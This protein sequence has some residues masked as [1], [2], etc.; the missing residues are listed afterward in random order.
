VGC[1]VADQARLE[2]AN[3]VH[4][5]AG[6]DGRDGFPQEVE[7]DDGKYNQEGKSAF[8][9]ERLFDRFNDI[10]KQVGLYH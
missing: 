1:K 5:T 4:R 9:E 2:Q 3:L 8:G 6:L 10:S 7:N